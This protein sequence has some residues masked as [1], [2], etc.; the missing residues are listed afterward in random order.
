[1]QTQIR[2]EQLKAGIDTTKIADGSVTNT[3]FQYIN[4]L[5]SNVQDQLDTITSDFVPYTGATTDLDLGTHKLLTTGDIS[6]SGA[7]V[8]TGYF[9]EDRGCG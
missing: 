2:N 4:S 7:R 8:S 1:M 9:K 6:S 3:E 5:T